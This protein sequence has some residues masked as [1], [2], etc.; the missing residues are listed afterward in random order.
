MTTISTLMATQLVTAQAHESVTDVAKR[1]ADNGVG[2]V[3][4]VDEDRL[5]GLVSERD[6]LTR[7][8]AKHFDAD[9]TGVGDICTAAPATLNANQSLK[10]ALEIFRTRKFRHLPVVDEKGKPVG[11]VSTTDLHAYLVDELERFVDD[12]KYKKLLSDGVDPY[13][14]FGGQYGR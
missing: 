13:D 10:D 8:L 2:A 6:L 3:L 4:I 1:M 12:L 11:L 5:V 7:V 14:H 9:T